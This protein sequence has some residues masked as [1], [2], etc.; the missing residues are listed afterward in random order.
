MNGI[1]PIINF[2]GQATRG[3]STVIGQVINVVE[4]ITTLITTVKN[5]ILELQANISTLLD[6]GMQKVNEIAGIV[7]GAVENVADTL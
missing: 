5:T 1:Q 2:I 3:V 6:M 7:K 4:N